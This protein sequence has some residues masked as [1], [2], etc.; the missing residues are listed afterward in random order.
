[1][2]VTLSGLRKVRRSREVEQELDRVVPVAFSPREPDPMLRQRIEEALGSL[3]EP[4]RL[5]VVMHDLEGFTHD[6]IGRTLDIPSGT[7]KARLSRARA[8]LRPL[9]AECAQ[10]YATC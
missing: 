7:S 8:R 9:L 2:N 3:P 5:V 1:V 6:E 10:E 4:Y